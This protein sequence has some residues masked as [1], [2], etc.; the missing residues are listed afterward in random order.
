MS[1]IHNPWWTTSLWLP[2]L[3]LR[4]MIYHPRWDEA[5]PCPYQLQ[6]STSLTA[7]MTCNLTRVQV[8]NHRSTRMQTRTKML[9]PTL[10]QKL[11]FTTSKEGR[12]RIPYQTHHSPTPF[13]I[14]R[15]K[16]FWSSSRSVIQ[17]ATLVRKWTTTAIHRPKIYKHPIMMM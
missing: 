8:T 3:T 7:W 6:H 10:P 16:S 17:V 12:I 5:R 4:S 13:Q 11:H 9:I 2:N 14:R 15:T 1:I